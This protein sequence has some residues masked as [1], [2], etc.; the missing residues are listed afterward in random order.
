GNAVPPYQLEV[1]YELFMRSLFN[2]YLATGLISMADDYNTIGPDSTWHIK[3]KV[4]EIPDPICYILVPETCTEEQYENVVN[5][6]AVIKDWQLSVLR[7]KM[8]ERMIWTE[9]MVLGMFS[10]KLIC[11]V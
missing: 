11:R 3:N 1:A 6:T 8:R 2:K 10:R 4:P 7:I 9:L 5:C